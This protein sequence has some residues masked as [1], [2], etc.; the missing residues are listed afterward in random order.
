MS[1]NNEDTKMAYDDEEFEKDEDLDRIHQEE[2]DI[3]A[4]ADELSEEDDLY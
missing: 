3:D 2:I 4:Y 1:Q